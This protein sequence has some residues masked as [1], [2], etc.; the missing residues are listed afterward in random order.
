MS[1][2]ELSDVSGRGDAQTEA[3]ERS[4][5][6]DGVLNHAESAKS[7]LAQEASTENGAGEPQRL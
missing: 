3:R 1:R 2:P 6:A 5:H 4:E 7:L